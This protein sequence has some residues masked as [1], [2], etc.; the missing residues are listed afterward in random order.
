MPKA[1][2]DIE[3][4]G[5]VLRK[6]PQRF[7]N[8]ELSWLQFNRRVFEEASNR[9]HPLLEQLRFLSISADNLDEFFMVRV[10]GLI[11]QL[12]SGVATSSQDGLTPQE[13]LA[14]ISVAVSHL[15]SDQQRRWRELRDALLEE[16]IVLTE[17]AGLTKAEA[18]WLEDYFLSHV[19]P[20]LTPLAIDP[21]HPFPFIPNL[22]SSIAL[23][24]VRQSDGKVLN[25]LIRLPSRAERFIR[26]PDFAETGATRFIPLEQMIVLYTSRLFPGYD[27]QGQGAFRVIRDSDIEVEEEAE[28]LVRL[29]ETALKQRRRGSVI[30]LEVETAMPE[31][32]RL[33]VAEELEVSSDE[34]FV[35]EGMMG[36][37]DLSQL[38]AL[39]R[40]DLKF[41]PYNPRFPERIREHS[42]D[43]FAAIREKDIIVHHPYESFDAVVQFLRQAARDPN[44]VAI[45]QTLYRTSS[46]SPI[47]AA[48]AEA[49]EAGKSVTALVE[50]K[51]RFDEEANIRWA[52][53]LERA[54]A[55]V[56]FGFI[57][58]KTHAKLSMVVRR[59]GSQLITYCHVG[60]GNY[61][62]ITARIYT[63]LSY[64]TADPVIGRDVSRI[65]NYVTGYAEP[66]ELERMAVSPLTLKKR[67][68]QHIAEE[69]EHARAGRPGAI[70]GKCNSLV[71]PDI[72]DALYDASAAG[73][74]IDLIV[75][76]I[77]CLR[78]GIK[79]LSENIRVKS[80]VGRFLEHTRIYAFGNGHGM[81][82]PKAHVYI[83]SADL[84]SR[85]LDRRVEAL[86]PIV[87]TTVHQQVLDQ[88]MLANLLDNE[89]SWT[90]LPDGSSQRVVPAKGEEPFNAHKYFMTNPSL[91]GR[92]KSLKTSSPK[93][94]A[95]RGQR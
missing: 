48:L 49:A 29:F 2:P 81:P 53:D 44:V 16:G 80:I 67:L 63:D 50:L 73:V 86:M 60:T 47:V 58:L 17:G 71:D 46:D 88:I 91:S 89:Q 15:A 28:D 76:G 51:A 66:A 52:R 85:N 62:P 10:A 26:L 87:N 95:K 78:P 61:H 11:G 9:N 37:R 12:R 36:L 32:L 4:D 68:L 41:K 79:G 84:M 43:C 23:K 82:N 69:V 19:F 6:F 90:V 8:R 38:V 30:R 25:A 93:A 7:I 45:K 83:S 75:R 94:L 77:C 13:Q 70:W 34:V 42:G 21:A 92:G 72:I 14:K 5:A 56:V 1:P 35:V 33:F 57:E 59:E 74:Q 27:V 39:E 31:D 18:S 24:L 54:G 64:F 55:Q 20:I 65:F 40:P 22:G 3:L